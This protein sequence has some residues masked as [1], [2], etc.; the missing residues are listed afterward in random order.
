[1]MN[2]NRLDNLPRSIAKRGF[3]RISHRLTQWQIPML[4]SLGVLATI[5]YTPITPVRIAMA[6]TT[7]IAIGGIFEASYRKRRRRTPPPPTPP[8]P[9][10]PPAPPPPFSTPPPVPAPPSPLSTQ[11][12]TPPLVP[13]T[14]LAHYLADCH[15]AVLG[16][17]FGAPNLAAA[18]QLC[19]EAC[20]AY[21]RRFQRARDTNDDARD[22]ARNVA[23]IERS[24]MQAVYLWERLGDRMAA[25]NA[26]IDLAHGLQRNHLTDAVRR[27]RQLANLVS[28][29]P[30]PSIALDADPLL[31]AYFRSFPG[32]A[33]AIRAQLRAI[34]TPL[35]QA[36]DADAS[37]VTPD[38]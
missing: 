27:L 19:R 25:V 14:A 32:E 2:E 9:V 23:A 13:T 24:A 31:N 3:N 8:P 38:L 6:I 35:Q 37:R 12:P 17:V 1:M 18:A 36:L 33:D 15:A 5:P 29:R 30:N 4:A 22:D 34:I 28:E 11:Q 10:S 7:L 16:P 26:L 20:D 21:V